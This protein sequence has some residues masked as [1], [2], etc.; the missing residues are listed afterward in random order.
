MNYFNQVVCNNYNIIKHLVL[1]PY[2]TFKLFIILFYFIYCTLMVVIYN[3]IIIYYF[4]CT[5]YYKIP[6]VVFI[7]TT[8]LLSC[9]YPSHSIFSLK[10]FTLAQISTYPNPSTIK[11]SHPQATHQQAATKPT[12]PKPNPPTHN[13]T[14]PPAIN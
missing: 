5:Y 6:P 9:A 11:S 3:V 8:F 14:P 12:C 4:H 2:E 13:Q 7:I 10:A 1:T